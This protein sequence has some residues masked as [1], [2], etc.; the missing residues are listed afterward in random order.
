MASADLTLALELADIADSMTLG[1]FGALDLTVAAK[2]DRTPVS[3]AD[4]AVEQRMRDHLTATR[5]GDALVG[6]EFGA[7]G[8]AARR[9]IVDPIDGTA[10]F[11]RRVPVWC[12]LIALEVDG[13]ITL[14]V[15]SAPAL[16]RRWW[17]ERGSGAFVRDIDGH[18][19]QIRVS[20]VSEVSDAS[21]SFSALTD[22]K[23]QG[24]LG[25][26]MDFATSCWRQRAYGD[27]LSHVLVAEGAVDIATEAVVAVWDVAA[28]EVLI[29]EAG[30]VC[31]TLD[32]EPGATGGTVL[33]TNGLLHPAALAALGGAASSS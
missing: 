14:G 17:A 16:G 10:N 27:F 31:T 21:I 15:V 13:Q 5:P 8:E 33:S 29:S 7:Q 32:G 20:Q 4:L 28:I 22:W 12:T 23:E 25:A 11:V 24:R 26:L 9:W 6:E 30:G 18:V 1:R 19:R 3:D 2:P